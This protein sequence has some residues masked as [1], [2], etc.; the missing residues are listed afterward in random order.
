MANAA[1]SDDPLD[2]I[3]LPRSTWGRSQRPGRGTALRWGIASSLVFAGLLAG[4]LLTMALGGLAGVGAFFAIP[5][6]ADFRLRALEAKMAAGGREEAGRWLRTFEG[7]LLV[8]LLAPH[9]WVALQ[10][11]RLHMLLADGRAAATALADCARLCRGTDIPGLM[12]ARAH[13]MVA[14]GDRKEARRLLE[15][16]VERGQLRA[17][18]RLDYGIVLLQDRGRLQQAI[19]ELERAREEVGDHPRLL[20][21]LAVALQ[22]SEETDRAVE[23]FERA[24]KAVGGRE[25]VVAEDL[26]KRAR[27]ALRPQ[28]RPKGKRERKARPVAGT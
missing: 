7:D 26:L 17:R 10:K 9:A 24:Q 1:L 20:A 13:A 23:L 11:G 16:L 21:A 25:D 14:S 12:S 2:Q 8:R 4:D 18:D 3:E 28:L 6:L 19:S 27:K 5:V 15:S 22:R